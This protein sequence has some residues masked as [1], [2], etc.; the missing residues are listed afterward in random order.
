MV[1]RLYS[2]LRLSSLFTY[3][4]SIASGLPAPGLVLLLILTLSTPLCSQLMEHISPQQRGFIDNTL[5]RSW[6]PATRPSLS[7]AALS[8]HPALTSS[9][10]HASQSASAS[11]SAQSSPWSQ[12][13][14]LA[15]AQSNALY[16]SHSIPRNISD[17]PEQAMNM[18]SFSDADWGSLFAAPLNP[19]V[20]AA[21]AANGVLGP[22]SQ[23]TPSS[24]PAQSFQGTFNSSHMPSHHQD[25]ASGT[26]GSW[27]QPSPL[28]VPP[29]G[30]SNK[31]SAL[32]RSNRSSTEIHRG[33]NK[34]LPGGSSL[35][36]KLYFLSDYML[37]IE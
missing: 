29:S 3:Q 7:S 10:E 37:I 11:P 8:A 2:L 16:L 13:A 15:L 14:S 4:D 22:T 35:L 9:S 31:S 12:N 30:Y 34:T 6:S 28:Y 17:P 32:S 18:H 5:S 25:H 27:T 26:P 20:F 24:L 19:S 1:E 36:L 23:G 33:K 21:L